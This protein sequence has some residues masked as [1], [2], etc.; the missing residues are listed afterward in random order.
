MRYPGVGFGRVYVHVDGEFTYDKWIR[1][2]DAGNSF[3]TTGPMLLVEFNGQRAGTVFNDDAAKTLHITGTAESRLPLDRIEKMYHQLWSN[4]YEDNGNRLD[5]LT[6]LLPGQWLRALRAQGQHERVRLM[7]LEAFRD[8]MSRYRAFPDHGI[9]REHMDTLG[10]T[11]DAA[12]RTELWRALEALSSPDEV[13]R[14]IKLRVRGAGTPDE[15]RKAEVTLTVQRDTVQLFIE[16][17]GV[18][19]WL[20]PRTPQ[21]WA[22]VTQNP[23]CNLM[24]MTLLTGG[25]DE[26]HLRS[27]INRLKIEGLDSATTL[28]GWYSRHLK[29]CEGRHRAGITAEEAITWLETVVEHIGTS[30]ED[31][32]D[33]MYAVNALFFDWKAAWN[34]PATW[35]TVEPYRTRLLTLADWA[36]EHDDPD[37]ISTSS[38]R[39]AKALLTAPTPPGQP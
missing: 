17:L 12:V 7:I 32:L 28:S 18:H 4:D 19:P 22:I 24:A 1:G 29:A 20:K 25:D 2:L 36:I 15:T 38:T 37:G 39:E 6:S 9:L 27:V 11:E 5:V 35:A 14:L 30:P 21:E 23:L 34:D 33:A 10:A 16:A 8:P 13:R 3:V 31:R 26:Q